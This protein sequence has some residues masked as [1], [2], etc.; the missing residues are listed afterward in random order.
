MFFDE[1][2]AA[3]WTDDYS[4]ACIVEIKLASGEVI[5]SGDVLTEAGTLE[6]IVADEFQNKATAEIVLTAEAVFGLDN[7]QDK[8]FHVDQEVVLL[9]GITFAEGLT[10]KKVE[11]EE[12]GIRTEIP[13]PSAFTPEFPGI[14]SIILTLERIDGSTIEVRVDQIRVNALS[15]NSISISDIKPEDILPIINQVNPD[16]GDTRA[17]ERIEHIRVAE[18][19]RIRDMMWEYGASDHSSEEYQAL[20]R[21]LTT[22]MLRENPLGY[23][24]YE[25][26]GGTLVHE[27]TNHAHDEWH[28][29]NLLVKYANFSVI[30][31]WEHWRLLYELCI[32]DPNKINIFG[33]SK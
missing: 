15:Y 28:T 2:V 9:N 1:S 8:A 33:L 7:M 20:M 14:I 29:L 4:E 19:T 26:V 11:V 17:Y 6:I 24:N 31:Q 23:D 3:T 22:G 12:N 25:I 32:S 27:P 18:A 21:R 30:D 10:L 16:A 13:N 5:K